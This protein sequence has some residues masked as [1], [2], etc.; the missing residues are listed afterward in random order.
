MTD[1][2]KLALLDKIENSYWASLQFLAGYELNFD[3]TRGG[4]PPFGKHIE[5]IERCHL[6]RAT[7]SHNQTENVPGDDP[8]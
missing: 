2:E 8:A 4:E 7:L 5:T 6:I 1:A 3:P